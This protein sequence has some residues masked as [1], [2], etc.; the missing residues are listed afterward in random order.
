[1]QLQRID[2][3][4]RLYVFARQGYVSTLGFDILNE[5]H[6]RLADEF[7]F[8]HPTECGT[9]KAFGD[10][11]QAMRDAQATNKRSFCELTAQLRG[12][13]GKK[14]QV[15]TKDGETHTFKLGMS[16]GWQPIHLAV[17]GRGGYPVE[18]HFR[19]VKVLY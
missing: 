2:E 5:R 10:Y 11:A 4:E 17:T 6:G 7:G 14:V 15:V 8:A 13:E 18:R 16:T 19:S 9:A 12:L 1:M 3:T